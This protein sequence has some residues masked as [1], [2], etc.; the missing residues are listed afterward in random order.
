MIIHFCQKDIVS[1]LNTNSSNTLLSSD[2]T[3]TGT[4]IFSKLNIQNWAYIDG[5]GA[6]SNTN[7][8]GNTSFIGNLSK[9]DSFWAG[10]NEFTL[11]TT[12]KISSSLTPDYI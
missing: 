1:L 8:D 2:N 7:I 12:P 3:F 10:N 5:T 9:T 4:N 11:F 6:L